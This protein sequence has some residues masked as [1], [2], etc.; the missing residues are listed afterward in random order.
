MPLAKQKTKK[1]KANKAKIGLDDTGLVDI[2]V[3]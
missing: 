1:F 2:D 3:L